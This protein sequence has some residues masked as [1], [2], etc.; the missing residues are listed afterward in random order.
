MEDGNVLLY[1]VS[2]PLDVYNALRSSIHKLIRD[3]IVDLFYIGLE[4]CECTPLKYT[5]SMARFQRKNES[6]LCLSAGFNRCIWFNAAFI[7]WKCLERGYG[8][9]SEP[10]YFFA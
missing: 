10:A 5:I 7:R 1:S 2:V 3:S 8:K 4:L 9:I 6:E